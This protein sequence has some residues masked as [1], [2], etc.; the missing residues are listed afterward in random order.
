M[1]NLVSDINI[2]GSFLSIFNNELDRLI[3]SCSFS[4]YINFER[5]PIININ[6]DILNIEFSNKNYIFTDF[7]KKFK[8]QQFS[9]F[10]YSVIINL[11]ISDYTLYGG[12]I[13]K[14]FKDED[15]EDLDFLYN[16]SN[17][18]EFCYYIDYYN[19]YPQLSFI[20]IIK[21]NINNKNIYL[22]IYILY[23]IIYNKNINCNY[24]KKYNL[25]NLVHFSLNF[26]N[27]KIDLNYNTLLETK[28]DFYENMLY[29][30][31]KFEIKTSKEYHYNINL[32]LI[33]ISSFIPNQNLIKKSNI[34]NIILD[35]LGNNFACVLESIYYIVK[36]K[37]RLCHDNCFNEIKNNK[38]LNEIK[39]IDKITHYRIPKFKLKGY[40]PIF[41]QKCSKTNCICYISELINIYQIGHYQVDF[42]TFAEKKY[43][44][45]LIKCPLIIYQNI[46]NLY[47][48]ENSLYI[49]NSI[50][51][52]KNKNKNNLSK[53]D[54]ELNNLFKN[55]KMQIVENDQY[56]YKKKISKNIKYDSII[57]YL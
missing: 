50:D 1:S 43:S 24:I 46:S 18:Q 5:I 45:I 11:G 30:N 22:I 54:F 12:M 38:M 7:F 55:K 2:N 16:I 20:N 3:E 52:P 57:K 14:M 40:K 36:N 39:S 49:N 34:L 8:N 31:N 4:I 27:F 26:D 56:L 42:F 37:I 15:I 23:K 10:L 28:Y 29:L 51:S 6:P 53:N 41:T 19:Q 35:M 44:E 47:T 48:Q 13:R 17:F 21:E 9:Y 33:L 32:S 25:K